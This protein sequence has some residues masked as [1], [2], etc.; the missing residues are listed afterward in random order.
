MLEYEWLGSNISSIDDLIE[1]GKLYDKTKRYNIDL[2]ILN[3]LV[4]Q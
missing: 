2:K 3:K 4:N 1:L